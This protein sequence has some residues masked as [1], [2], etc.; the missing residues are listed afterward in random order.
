MASPEL[1]QEADYENRSAFTTTHWSVILAAGTNQTAGSGAALESLCKTY[2]YPLYAFVRRRGYDACEAQDLT[3]EFFAKLLE[4]NFLQQ[5][6]RRKGKFRSFLLGALEHFLANEWRRSRAEKRG[7]KVIFVSL[8]EDPEN[9]YQQTAST[10]LSP[11]QLFEQQWATKL[12]EQV[13]GQLREEFIAAGKASMFE[14]LKIFLTGEKEAGCYG[15]LAV[16]LQ[17]TEG[18]LKMAVSRMR[19]RYGHLLRT[20]IAN[21]VSSPEEVE[22]ELRGLLAALRY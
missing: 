21:T 10:G 20:E 7:G 14:H 19:Q 16:R 15:Q 11:E 6:D 12:L 22:E 13:V 17:S 1:H 9:Q 2:W 18:A 4:K 5:V 3:Q 8:D